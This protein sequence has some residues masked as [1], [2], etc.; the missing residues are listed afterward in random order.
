MKRYLVGG[1]VRDALLGR[2]NSDR[3][4]VVVGATAAQMLADGYVSVGQDFP[5]FLHPQTHEEH[6]LARTERKVAAGYA[7]FR[8]DADPS[9]TLEQDLL[10]RDLTINAMAR[11]EDGTVIDPYGG[12]QDLH[13]KILRHVSAAFAEDPVRILRLARFAA[14]FGFSVAESTL[15]LMRDM[16]ARGEVDA[17]VPE[18]VW[19]EFSRGLLERQPTRFFEVLDACGALAVCLPECG[20]LADPAGLAARGLSRAA[21]LGLGLPAR[22][23]VLCLTIDQ[24][25]AL[26]T[27]L[28]W[29]THFVDL[30]RLCLAQRPA[31]LKPGWQPED[32]LMLLTLIERSDALRRPQRLEEAMAGVACLL[33]PEA[34]RGVLATVLAALHAAQ[35]VDAGAIAAAS[36]GPEIPLRVREARRLAVENLLTQRLRGQSGF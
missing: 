8:F 3:D 18:R 17:L 19:Q 35:A 22:V 24:G 28:R 13:D 36:A 9:V 6:A 21:E 14:R 15:Q 30:A 1:A 32:A 27:R 4:W 16:V 7:G 10:R 29:P 2:P 5:V 25:P 11:D 34:G 31:L 23:A 26:A 33:A 20:P 12:R